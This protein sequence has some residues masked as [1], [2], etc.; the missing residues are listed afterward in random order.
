MADYTTNTT[1]EAANLGSIV[2]GFHALSTENLLDVD[3]GAGI[4]DGR[5]VV[6]TIDVGVTGATTGGKFRGYLISE[7]GDGTFTAT[8]G[9]DDLDTAVLAAADALL[10]DV[11]AGGVA[12]LTGV[13]TQTTAVAQ[14]KSVAR[15]GETP[16]ITVD[17]VLPT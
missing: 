11:P 4:V 12:I 5:H 16:P 15:Q 13:A 17:G 14:L 7:D 2:E 1:L 8:A 9:T 10:I 3:L 6:A